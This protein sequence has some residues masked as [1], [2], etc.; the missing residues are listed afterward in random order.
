MLADG[1]TVDVPGA[2]PVEST[3]R[4][5]PANDVDPVLEWNQIL[6]DTVLSS[7]PAPNSLV[8]SRS[9]ALVAAA[10]FDAVNGVDSGTSRSTSRP[11]PRHTRRDE[12]P[13]SKR[14]TQC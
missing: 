4:M 14:R 12:L 6:N 3:Y 9:A 11:V 1:S 2:N 8:T 7:V 5:A 10:V 13:R